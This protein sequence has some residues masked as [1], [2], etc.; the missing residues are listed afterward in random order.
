[1]ANGSS[2][3]HWTIVLIDIADFTSPL[4]TSAHHKVLHAALYEVLKTAFAE[5]GIDW[6]RCHVEDRGDGAMILVPADVPKG[7]LVDPLPD[8]L[9][10]AL[11]RHN[12]LH[13]PEAAMQLRMVFHFGEINENPSGA[14]GP[15]LNDAF[16]LLGAP[17]AKSALRDSGGTLAI[18]ASKEFYREVIMQDPAA[19]PDS[20]RAISVAVRHFSSDAWLRLPDAVVPG[21]ANDESEL[22]LGLVPESDRNRV[23]GWLGEIELA[24]VTEFARRAVGS[25]VTLPPFADPWEA[26]TH[27]ADVNAGPDGVPPC[28]VYLDAVAT[29]VG[30]AIG[31]AM[32]EWVDWQVRQLRIGS[33]FQ[34]Y[35]SAS[36]STV[37]DP[38]LHL[39]ILLEQDAID[40]SRYLLSSWRQTDPEQWPPERGAV[41]EVV[42]GEF[43][44]VV[45]DV[46]VDAE[47]AWAEQR[48]SVTL[49]F[50]LPRALLA[51]PVHRWHKEHSSDEPRP[52]CL[53]YRIQIRSLDRLKAVHWHRVW[54]ERWASM[55]E[56]PSAERVH[57]TPP[58][59]E[60][61]RVEAELSDPLWVSAVIE[62]PSPRAGGGDALTAALRSGL[63]VIMWHP[64]LPPEELRD[65]VGWLVEDGL[66]GLPARSEFSRRA[67]IGPKSLPYF[68]AQKG[69]DVVIMWDDPRRLVALDQPLNGPLP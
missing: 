12:A 18:V 57:F 66:T 33:A 31:G 25:G 8:R 38:R 27:L 22:V 3:V 59:L 63:P 10:A 30:G 55:L 32:A 52:L 36:S 16:R 5:V 1:M 4:R 62:S 34:K 39:V 50:V 9:L 67:A 28:L 43:E 37:D 17:A 26:F 15:A 40:R 7:L 20:Y 35:R 2:T 49:E 56:D 65:V 68:D 42:A 14:D 58:R 48:A 24:N 23:Q 41:R 61:G 44:R 13:V 64:E 60:R 69:R 6:D 45:D 53:D 21:P 51:T 29:H 11:R 47:R 46:V 54:R 19:A